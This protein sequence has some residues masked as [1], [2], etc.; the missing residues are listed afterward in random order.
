MF[1]GKNVK[2]LLASAGSG[3]T[4]RLIEEVATELETRRAEEIA[5]VTFTR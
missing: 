3:K 2:V 1:E 5:F 4:R